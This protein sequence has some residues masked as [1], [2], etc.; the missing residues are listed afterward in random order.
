MLCAISAFVMV[1]GDIAYSSRHWAGWVA[2]GAALLTGAAAFLIFA[3]PVAAGIIILVL[4]LIGVLSM[5]LFYINTL[6]LLAVPF[7]F[8]CCILCVSD[9]GKSRL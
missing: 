6:Y 2:F 5:N 3:R 1:G 8:V 7:W 4:T 9:V